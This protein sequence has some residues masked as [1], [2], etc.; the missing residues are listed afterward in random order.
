MRTLREFGAL[1]GSNNDFLRER[2]LLR[3][4]TVPRRGGSGQ[5]SVVRFY[6]GGTA[7]LGSEGETSPLPF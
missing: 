1:R 4:E 6:P 3:V 5:A 2:K 7:K